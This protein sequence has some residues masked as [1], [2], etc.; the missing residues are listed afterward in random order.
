V[1]NDV[2]QARNIV[3]ASGSIAELIR[4]VRTDEHGNL[5]IDFNLAKD[6]VRFSRDYVKL[7]AKTVRVYVAS[8]PN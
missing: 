3:S 2:E 6:S 4:R 8:K 7:D 1:K 5:V